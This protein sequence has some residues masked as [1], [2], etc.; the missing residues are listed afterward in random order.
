MDALRISK[1]L[2]FYTSENFRFTENVNCPSLTHGDL[3][4]TES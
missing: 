4:A 2:V 1:F 3:A